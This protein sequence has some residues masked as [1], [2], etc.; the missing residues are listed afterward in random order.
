MLVNSPELISFYKTAAVATSK[1]R[2]VKLADKD[3]S[4]GRKKDTPGGISSI[5]RNVKR[6]G[7]KARLGRQSVIDLG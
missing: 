1:L 3:T 5:Q 7:F 2:K 4:L 6:I